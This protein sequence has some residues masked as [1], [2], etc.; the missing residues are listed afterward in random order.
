MYGM[1]LLVLLLGVAVLIAP[2]VPYLGHI[3]VKIV[4]SGS[5]EP[6]INTGGIVVIREVPEYGVGDVITFTSLT[7]DIP[8]THRIIGE[9]MIDGKRMFITKGDANEERDADL[10]PVPNVIGRV[11]FDVP[12]LGFIL[13]F[14]RQPLGFGLLIGIPALLIILDE[15]EKIWKEVRRV[16]GQVVRGEEGVSSRKPVRAPMPLVVLPYTPRRVRMMDIRPRGVGTSV[17]SVTRPTGSLYPRTRFDMRIASFLLVCALT[18]GLALGHVGGTVSFARDLEG[19]T[20]NFFK[21][22]SVGFTLAPSQVD[23]VFEDRAVVEGGEHTL[24]TEMLLEGQSVPLRYTVRT[25]IASGVGALC[26]AIVGKST[27]LPVSG[28]ISALS[29]E[30]VVLP[31][32]WTL[33]LDLGEGAYV[34]GDTCTLRMTY[35]A[36]DA[37]LPEP[38]SYIDTESTL[39]TFVAPADVIIDI[40]QTLPRIFESENLLLNTNSSGDGVETPSEPQE[41]VPSLP[42]EPTIPGEVVVDAVVETIVD[43]VAPVLVEE[44]VVVN[45]EEESAPEDVEEVSAPLESTEE[46]EQAPSEETP[47]E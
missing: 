47:A 31:D 30:S 18:L 4:K 14:A 37:S 21:T 16:R 24:S 41:N 6:G 9:E 43:D 3:E 2:S 22:I 42:T 26:D 45:P 20:N 44:E 19:T 10:V 29:F 28:S 40:P 13:D 46:V 27:E 7:A 12:Y 32:S 39:I 23:F 15:I 34:G 33:T 35:E 17:P 1:F 36:W 11:L 38:M 5:M 25:E 8:T